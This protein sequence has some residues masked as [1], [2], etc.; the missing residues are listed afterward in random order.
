T[1]PEEQF[2]KIL[3][4]TDG[5]TYNWVATVGQDLQTFLMTQLSAGT[6]YYFKVVASNADGDSP[7]SNSAPVTTIAL[8]AAP[9]NLTATVPSG[10]RVNLSWTDNSQSGPTV[11]TSF[12]Q[13]RSTNQVSWSWFATTGQGVTSYAWTGGTPSTTY[14]FYVTASASVGDSTPSNT[15][16][17]TTLSLPAAPSNFTGN[18]FSTTRIDLSWTDNSGTGSTNPLATS[19]KLFRSTDQVNWSWFGTAGQGATSYTW[20][21]ATASSTYYFYVKASITSGDSGASNTITITTP[22]VPIAPSNVVATA[23]SSTKVNFSW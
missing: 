15:A 20:W 7:V 8:P 3:R 2:F 21:G 10:T 18:A 16:T 22:G 11:A 13:Y 5:V 6:S 1:N 23:A 12:K 19:F 14:Y 9:S 4:S 17:A